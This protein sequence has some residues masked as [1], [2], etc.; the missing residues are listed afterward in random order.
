MSA[1]ETTAESARKAEFTALYDAVSRWLYGYL[2][3]LLRHHEDADEVL[4]ETASVLWEKFDQYHRGTEFRAWA[5]RIAFYKAQ[6]F[7]RRNRRIP[8]SFSDLAIDV[9]DEEIVVMTDGLDFRSAALNACLEKLPPADRDILE[10]RYRDDDIET[11]AADVGRSPQTVYRTLARIHAT[12]FECI[13]RTI[14]EE[15]AS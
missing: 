8:A 9:V 3:S 1:R 15:Q 5:C 10:R 4:Q 6:N 13:N 7:R 2:F 14:A 12:L 11:I